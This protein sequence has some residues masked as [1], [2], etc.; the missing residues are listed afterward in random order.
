MPESPTTSPGIRRFPA[1]STSAALGASGLSACGTASVDRGSGI[2]GSSSETTFTE[3]RPDRVTP[4][5][6]TGANSPTVS[7]APISNR[8]LAHAPPDAPAELRTS[9]YRPPTTPGTNR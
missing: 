9:S 7:F 6:A 5:T 1:V 3:D 4:R 2:G 8:S